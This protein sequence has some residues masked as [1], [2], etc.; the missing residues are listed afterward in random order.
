MEK[1]KVFDQEISLLGLGTMRLPV[2]NNEKGEIDK[3]AASAIFDY[4]LNHGVNY[5]DTAYMYHNGNAEAFTGEVLAQYDRKSYVLA[6]KM[7]AWLA[8]SE[9][10]VER[11]FEGQLKKLKTDYFDFYLCHNLN[12]PYYPYFKKYKVMEYLARKKEEGLIKHLG[13]SFHDT[14]EVM[15][16][17][18]AD[19]DWEFGQIQLNYLDWEMQKAK[20]QYQLL[21]DKK[22]PVIVMEPLRGGALATLSP[23]A[24]NHLQK[25]HPTKTPADLGLRFAAQLPNVMTVLSGMSSLK[26]LKENIETMDHFAP[27]SEAE[28]KNLNI[29]LTLYKE[30]KMIPCTGCRY[31]DGCPQ[32]VDIATMFEI[33][34]HYR[35]G[36]STWTYVQEYESL[37]SSAH[38]DNCTACGKCVEK[39]PQ[40]LDIPALLEK[41]GEMIKAA[42]RNS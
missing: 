20:E 29:A 7:P 39:C 10:G 2:K 17:Y 18:L 15:K 41:T 12:I 3:E 30:N 24:L 8:H 22:L 40:G 21:T 31:C 37:P 9:A 16:Q 27:L 38:E 25:T 11:I 13:F 26:Q 28:Q 1:R 34:N 4:A 19:F 32:G 33:N 35:L 42:Y 23:D 5:I 36:G 6:T 14:P